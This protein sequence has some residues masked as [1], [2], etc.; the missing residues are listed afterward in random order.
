VTARERFAAARVARLATTGPDGPHVVPI[1]FAVAGD[2]IYH[3]VDHKPK[4]TTALKRLSNLEADPRASVLADGYDEDW[5]R[6]WW[7]RADGTARILPA[8]H[9]EAIGLLCERYPQ[10]AGRPPQGP[11]VAIDVSRWSEWSAAAPPLGGR[12]AS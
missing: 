8:G 10:Y 11:V 5:E 4:R 2:T 9:E 3:A 7:V 1:V 6:L 12:A